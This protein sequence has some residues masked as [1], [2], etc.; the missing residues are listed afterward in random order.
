MPARKMN[1]VMPFTEKLKTKTRHNPDSLLRLLVST[2]I[3]SIAVII[4]ISG[5]G[6]YRVF[7]GFVIKSAEQDSIHL[8]EMIIDMQKEFIFTQSGDNSIQLGLVG[9]DLP[10]FDR[11]LRRAV[12]PFLILKVKIYDAD[13][14]IVYC[15]DPSLVGKVDDA[16]KRLAR[17]LSGKVDTKMVTKDKAQDLKEEALL[18]VDVVETYVPIVSPDQRVLGSFEIYM[19][20]TPYRDQVRKGATVTTLLMALVM[21]GVFGFSYLLIR[22]GTSQLKKAQ[23]QLETIARTDPLTGITNRGYLLQRAEEDFT[24]VVRERRSLELCGASLS[25]IM[26]DIDHFKRI[27][28]TKGHLAGDLILKEV[29]E[30]FHSSVRPYDL[31]GRYGGEEFAA[32]MPN[33]TIEQSMTIARRIQERIRSQAFS[34][35]GESVTITVSLGL[36][37]IHDADTSLTDLI[38]RTDDALYR[39]KA[40]GRDQIAWDP[41]TVPLAS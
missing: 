25:C 38:K 5:S 31:S 35:N 24:R 26:I 17:A 8:C 13:K 7:S 39:A 18:D 23:S 21:A 41:E 29:A 19:D 2:A 4:V 28:D 40:G 14:R 30:R 27:N 15:T 11:N 33:T 37:R 3:I 36:A 20:V 1:H 10:E 9:Q 22:G 32:F 34:V 16:N 12:A 6:F